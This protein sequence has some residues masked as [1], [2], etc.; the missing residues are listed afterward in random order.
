M[1]I[2]L[3]VFTGLFFSVFV[4]VVVSFIISF[5][6]EDEVSELF[7]K[8]LNNRVEEDIKAGEVNLSLLRKFPNAVVELHSFE[9]YSVSEELE[10]KEGSFSFTA[11]EIYFQ[12]DVIDLFTGKYNLDNIY[13][14]Q[15]QL[16][17]ISGA[18]RNRVKFKKKSSDKVTLD[19]NK[20]VFNNLYYSIFNVDQSFSLEGHTSKTVLSGNVSKN[21]YDLKVDSKLFLDNLHV[22]HFPYLRRKNLR[23]SMNLLVTPDRYE[24]KSGRIYLEGLPFKTEGSFN[25]AEQLIDLSLRGNGLDI[26]NTSLY[27]P[28]KIKKQLEALPVKKGKLDFYARVNGPVKDGRPEFQ[29][30]FSLNRGE[31]LLNV[32]NHSLRLENVSV[33]GYV[34][35]GR[36][37]SPASSLMT[38]NN[39]HAEWN[40][41]ELNCNVELSDFKNPQLTIEGSAML[42][43]GEISDHFTNTALENSSGTV[44][45][46]YEYDDAM[47]HLDDLEHLIRSGRLT[48]DATFENV[49]FSK[50]RFKIDMKSGF[51]Y[52]DRDLNFDNLQVSLNENQMIVNGRF[53]RIY[54]N[55]ADTS[56]PYQFDLTVES[57]GFTVEHLLSTNRNAPDSLMNFQFPRKMDGNID[58]YTGWLNWG[59]FHASKTSGRITFSDDGLIQIEEVE[60]S[61][62][63]GKTYA[64]ATLKDTEQDSVYLLDSRFHL[65][66][67]NIHNVFHTFHNFGQQYIT[68]KNLKGFID[69]DVILKA[70][71]NN[72]LKIKKNTL[73]TL[74][75]FEINDGELIDF[76]PLIQTANFVK[77]SELKHVT[78]SQ[79][80]NE[81]TIKDRTVYIP[82][83]DINSSAFDITVSG[84]HNF[85]NR[86]S[87]NLNLLLSQVLSRKARRKN[88]FQTEF[89]N[90][91][92]DGVGRTKLFLK[93]T[94]TPEKYAIQYDKEGVKN[95]I[96]DNLR[97]EKKE[98]K[99]ILNEEFGWFEPDSSI[100]TGRSSDDRKN[101]GISWEEDEV[102]EREATEMIAPSD[103]S[104]DEKGKFIIQWEDDTL[105]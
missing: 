63:Q 67:I 45:L 22:D 79:L 26:E 24:V 41:S 100:Q 32:K 30:D 84:Y 13:V 82:E 90:I 11:E 74:S 17:I 8:E 2:V 35:N 93:I 4:I 66:H 97:Q 55:I 12:F 40:E 94:G 77:L 104:R 69:G 7:L 105:N 96:R 76:E 95:Q 59:N 88:D 53:N 51:A 70:N 101:F 58:F 81:I 83:M 48:G 99:T 52:L 43:F 61:A 62:F 103:S 6:Y 50:G 18:G 14:N 85:D 25:R 49:T 91:Q 65:D 89:G 64:S 15:S 75:D 38:L 80:S 21:E 73:C 56:K 78:F 23:L 60:F 5:I 20:L 1:R 92:E 34:S 42:H 28:W 102:K 10:G 37:N 46:N 33:K 31:M 72:N 44:S 3:S 9:L 47:E 29:A 86:F 54:E 98:L 19:I 36:Y 87:Y 27:V 57:P 71:L 39:L 68:H 16:N